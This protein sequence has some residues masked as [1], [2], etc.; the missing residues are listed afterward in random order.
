MHRDARRHAPAYRTHRATLR[1]WLPPNL[2]FQ[3]H[4]RPPEPARRTA[5]RRCVAPQRSAEPAHQRFARYR[6]ALLPDRRSAARFPAET[7]LRIRSLHLPPAARSKMWAQPPRSRPARSRRPSRKARCPQAEAIPR[8]RPQPD[9]RESAAATP[10]RRPQPG[11]RES[12]AATPRRRPPPGDRESAAATPRRRPGRSDSSPAY[13]S[14]E[15]ARPDRPAAGRMCWLWRGSGK[16]P[17]A[18]AAN[19]PP[20]SH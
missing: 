4:R 7:A 15:W 17:D 3:A 8:R 20:A 19:R 16:R 6:R 1:L 18:P 2:C 10:H 14:A 5:A 13:R 12:A 9:D 11:D